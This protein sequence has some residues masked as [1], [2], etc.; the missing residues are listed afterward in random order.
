M[1]FLFFILVSFLIVQVYSQ[2]SHVKFIR[3]QVLVVLICLSSHFVF[4]FT[5]KVIIMLSSSSLLMMV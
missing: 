4:D 1:G 5:D 2:V 3:I